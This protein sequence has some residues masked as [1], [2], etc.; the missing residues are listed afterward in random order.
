MAKVSMIQRELKK[1]KLVEKYYKKRTKLKII[2]AKP[3]TIENDRW[4]AQIK[5]QKL[6]V[7]SSR[8]RL[9]NCCVITGRP[10]GVYS[11]FGLCRNKF[12]EYAMSGD[13]P[14]LIKA[15]W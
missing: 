13:I 3:E 10:R 5:L 7:N 14:G 1:R 11:K 9:R 12:R 15:S 2:I 6:P 8:S 4:E